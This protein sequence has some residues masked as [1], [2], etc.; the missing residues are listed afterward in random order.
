MAVGRYGVSLL[1]AI[2]Q[3]LLTTNV[4][5]SDPVNDNETINLIPGLAPG[6]Y[7]IRIVDQQS[8]V[9]VTRVIIQ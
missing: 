5:V 3:T 8:Q 4:Q 1:N 9:S 7:L 6:A 2:G